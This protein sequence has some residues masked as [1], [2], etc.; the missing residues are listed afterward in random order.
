MSETERPRRRGKLTTAQQEYVV[1][2][3]AAF[4][5]PSAIA[6]SLRDELDI[7]IGHQ[8]VG[9]YDPTRFR[10]CPRRWKALFE[11]KR[12]AILQDKGARSAAARA[13]RMRT[14]ERVALRTI[15]SLAGGILE[16]I[17]RQAGAGFVS[18]HAG[19][20]GGRPLTDVERARAVM[21]LLQKV[22]ADEAANGAAAQE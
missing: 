16:N 14:R 10:N 4:D 20:P 2:R 18:P 13:V 19:K 9:R 6:R 5:S 17:A 3:L 12:L 15:E 7:D 11:A 8:A 22:E 1:E 21:A